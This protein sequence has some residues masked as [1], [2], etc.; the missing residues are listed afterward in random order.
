MIQDELIELEKKIRQCNPW[1]KVAQEIGDMDCFIENDKDYHGNYRF[2]CEKD[3]AVIKAFNAK[4]KAESLY[5]YKL[6]IPPYPFSGNLLTAKIVILSLNPGYIEYVNHDTADILCEN[7]KRTFCKANRRWLR[8]DGNPMFDAESRK[9]ELALGTDYWKRRLKALADACNKQSGKPMYDEFSVFEDVAIMQYIGYASCKYAE[10]VAIRKLAED[11]INEDGEYSSFGFLRLLLQYLSKK[12]DVILI[13]LV[14]RN[15][16]NW[17]KLFNSKEYQGV[18]ATE[19][20]LYKLLKDQG[21]II[22]E[23]KSDMAQAISENNLENKGFQKLV[24]HLMKI[25]AKD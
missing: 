23:R 3:Q 13:F 14:L 18:N 25:H 24:D 9:E 20:G 11:S 16:K 19:E 7:S 8:L 22:D 1:E 15:K 21:H 2:V 12:D 4:Q 5:T 10:T 6:N 17:A